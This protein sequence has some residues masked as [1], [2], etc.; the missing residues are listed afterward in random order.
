MTLTATVP[1]TVNKAPAPAFAWPKTVP[2]ITYGDALSAAALPT[3]AHGNFAWQSGDTILSA[4]THTQT[5]V[6]S[7]ADTANYDYTGVTLT[8]AATVTVNKAP[9]P[10][11]V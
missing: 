5:I 4:G 7:P 1:V 6:Y 8:A 2:A 9:A 10:A 3:D 11:I